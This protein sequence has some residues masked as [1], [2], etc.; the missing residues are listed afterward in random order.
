MSTS[1]F[2]A[3]GRRGGGGNP[4]MDR[5]PIQWE[6]EILLVASRFIFATVSFIVKLKLLRVC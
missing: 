1:E 5:Y 3:G 6:V 2:N 4:S